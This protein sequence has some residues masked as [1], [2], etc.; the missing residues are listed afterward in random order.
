MSQSNASNLISSIYKSRKIFLD[1]MEKQEYNVDDYKNFSINEV[2][3]MLQNSQLDMLI[4]KRNID[5]E[6]GNKNKLYVRYYLGKTLGIKN[7]Q[8]MID[9]LFELS[10]TLKKT[11]TLYIITK[12]DP[13]ET[14]VGILK[15]IWETQ[16]IFIVVQNV[17]NL[18]FNILENSLVPPHRILN[19]KEV[20]IIKKKYNIMKNEEFA[21][22]SRFDPVSRVICIRP[23]QVCEIIRPS[24][25]AITGYYY[26]ICV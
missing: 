13:N 14:L 7:I 17:K 6:S 21:E 1:L 20:E 26:R 24:K 8:E 22:I 11:D 12:T 4:E 10:E 19:S 15:H 3:S 23:G 25:T 2:N 18:L 16:G 5:P 9:D